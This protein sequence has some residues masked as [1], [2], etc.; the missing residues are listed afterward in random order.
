MD[1]LCACRLMSSILRWYLPKIKL[2]FYGKI[3]YWELTDARHSHLCMQQVWTS[4]L[5]NL[6]WVS[7]SWKWPSNVFHIDFEEIITHHSTD[8]ESDLLSWWQISRKKM[9]FVSLPK[10]VYILPLWRRPISSLETEMCADCYVVENAWATSSYCLKRT[11]DLFMLVTYPWYSHDQNNFNWNYVSKE[12]LKLCFS[13]FVEWWGHSWDICF[14]SGNMGTSEYIGQNLH[15]VS[16]HISH[17]HWVMGPLI[18][19]IFSCRISFH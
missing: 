13:L 9:N 2:I 3:N 8:I 16:G 10:A 7:N 1:N 4:I 12:P 19:E 15:S 11:L 17:C 5:R 14:K 18:F 6:S